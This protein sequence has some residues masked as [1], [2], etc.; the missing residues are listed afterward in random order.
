[1]DA[2]KGN[3]WK[4]YF[5]LIFTIIATASLVPVFKLVLREVSVEEI[6]VFEYSISTLL[7]LGYF[8]LTGKAG[9]LRQH[10]SK[11]PYFILLAFFGLFLNRFLYLH[12][13]NFIQATE[14]NILYYTY[15]LTVSILGFLVLK[16]RMKRTDIIGLILGFLGAFVVIT[17]LDF[18]AFNLSILGDSLAIL[19]GVAYA[20]Y[21]VFSKK[22]KI[23]STILIVYTG[24]F[25]AVMSA[26]YLLFFSTF[27]I[28]SANS[29]L[30]MVYI[31]T[32]EAVLI[33]L[34]I[35]LLRA[36]NTFKIANAFYI[37]PFVV[38]IFNY[39]LLKEVIYAQYIIGLAL[40]VIG[41]IVQNMGKK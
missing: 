26:I 1:M 4:F 22:I 25:T 11:I 8:I 20:S 41:L 29:M 31:G 35:E 33:F 6:M 13:F 3:G 27:S 7:F 9:L 28:P 14:A 34:F 32:M 5:L 21:L 17:K 38:A 36:K 39:I 12:S 37:I 40:L 19:G 18:S 2:L 16:E 30:G 24:F 10:A 23:D 15:P